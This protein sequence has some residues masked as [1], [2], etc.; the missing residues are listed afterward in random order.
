MRLVAGV[1]ATAPRTDVVVVG[2]GIAG[3]TAALRLS[4]D[5]LGVTLVTKTVA[6]SGSTRWAQG[7]IAAALA[8]TD[9]SDAHFADTMGAGGGLCDPA[10][11]RVLVDDGPRRVR[12]LVSLGARFDL[13]HAARSP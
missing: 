8:P 6:S 1:R 12:A 5:G 10:A 9:S 7:G 13:D 2:S 11:V 4:A 3:L